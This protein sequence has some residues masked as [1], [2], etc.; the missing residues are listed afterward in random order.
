VLGVAES[1]VLPGPASVERAVDSV[2]PGRALPIVRLAGSHPHH[3]R[4]GWSY[5]YIADRSRAGVVEHRFPRRSIVGGFPYAAR[6]RSHIKRRR[7]GFD[8]RKIVDPAA[9]VCR[10]NRP[11]LETLQY[12]L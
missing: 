7:A 4:I 2:A 9:H 12:I 11:E 3:V 6:R 5:R 1:D 10:A 8:Y